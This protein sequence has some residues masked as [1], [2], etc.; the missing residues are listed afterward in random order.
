MVYTASYPEPYDIA[1][2][3]LPLVMISHD[4]PEHFGILLQGGFEMPVPK[5]S[6]LREFLCE[7]VGVC[8]VYTEKSLQTI[9]LDGLAVDD[10]DTAMIGPGSRLALSAAMPGLVGATMRR[11]GYYSRLRE[12]IS[13]RDDGEVTGDDQ[14]FRLQIRLYNA[15]GRDLA[16]LFLHQ[17]IIVGSETLLQFLESR[18]AVFYD[19]LLAATRDGSALP[20]D[21]AGIASW[22]LPPG[23]VAL[24]LADPVD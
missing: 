22:N 4:A 3:G 24:R 12:G 6:T 8:G 13:R 16:G 21:A 19:H 9:F 5:P 15:V 17:G 1:M 20:T 18:P 2:G 10:L 14:P 23:D 7:L 11:G